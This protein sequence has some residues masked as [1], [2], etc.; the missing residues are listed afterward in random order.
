MH[1]HARAVLELRGE[2]APELR[3]QMLAIA[4]AG[5]AGAGDLAAVAELDRR[6]GAAMP[7]DDEHAG[8]R[9][10]LVAWAQR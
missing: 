7:Q 4:M 2:L 1:A 10:F 5:A 3:Q 8:V 6:H 9:R